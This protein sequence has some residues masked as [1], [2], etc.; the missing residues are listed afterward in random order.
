MRRIALFVLM[1][2]VAVSVVAQPVPEPRAIQIESK[3]M[4]ETRNILVRTPPSYAVGKRAY[5]VLYMTDGDRQIG[6]TSAVVDF[7]AQS[8][9]DLTA[10]G[11]NGA[12][13]GILVKPGGYNCNGYSCDI[14]CAGNGSSQRQ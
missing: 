11:I 10:A 14:L 1:V 12:P 9:K 2:L 4:G 8:A 6:H 13:F 5:P 7:L 3:V